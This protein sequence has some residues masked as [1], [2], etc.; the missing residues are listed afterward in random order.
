MQRDDYGRVIAKTFYDAAGSKTPSSDGA[1]EAHYAYDDRGNLTS[2]AYFDAQGAPAPSPDGF[3]GVTTTYD[4]HGRSIRQSFVGPDGLPITNR[5]SGWA[6][7]TYVNDE[8][9]LIRANTT[10]VGSFSANAWGL[11]DMHGNV[12]HWCQ[13]WHGDYSQKDVVDPQGP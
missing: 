4:D 5:S 10:P 2:E 13:D 9:G 1:V 11:H 7:V 6:M 3:S 8:K 12:Q